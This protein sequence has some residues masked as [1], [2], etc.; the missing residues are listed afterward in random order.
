MTISRTAERTITANKLP[1][2]AGILAGVKKYWPFYIMLAPG[3][4]WYVVF[5]YI[6]IYGLVIAFKDFNIMEG[7][8]GS[9]WADPWYKYFKMFYDSPYFVQLLSNTV[10]ISLLKIVCGF[11]PPIIMALM[12][13]ECRVEWFKRLVQTITYMPHFL[14][15]VI[16]Y[17][18]LV[19]LFSEST[20][21]INKMI[22]DA[23][24]K[25]I[26]LLS[27]PE[28]F[29]QVLVGSEIW[30]E[31]G[32]SAIIYLASI[33][34]I[35]PALYEAAMIDGCGRIKRIWHITMPGIRN[36]IIMLFTLKIGQLLD[37]GFE[38]IY[39][40][41]NVHVYSVADIVDTWVFRTG[42]ESMNFSLAT[43]VGLFKSVIGFTL[44]VITNKIAKRWGESIW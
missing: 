30:K 29:R 19:S 25:A 26:P 11:L 2:A 40:M 35:D 13:N 18:L 44:V 33:A 21:I 36:V 41:Y 34:S 39:I 23:G 31:I 38:Q 5:K 7:I 32:W 37:A 24:G 22:V 17:G 43:A 12:L 3:L 42:L 9:P 20:G 27:S 8:V 10:I 14:S 15:W 28:L 6:P 16:V 1:V 4:L